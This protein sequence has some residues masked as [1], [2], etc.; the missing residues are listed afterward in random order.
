MNGNRAFGEIKISGRNQSTRRKPAK[1][2][3]PQKY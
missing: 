1:Q 2:S 3:A